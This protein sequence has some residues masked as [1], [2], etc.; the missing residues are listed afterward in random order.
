M[1]WA[2][3]AAAVA[4][5]LVQAVV[6][7][8]DRGEN[9]GIAGAGDPASLPFAL[10]TFRPETTIGEISAF[11]GETGAV[12]IAGPAAGGVFKIGIPADSEAEYDRIV[13]LIAAQPFAETVLAGR[14]PDD[15]G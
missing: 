7:P 6:E 4:L 15:G 11:L 1:A 2:A 8:W 5:L 10:V 12:V 3:A 9:F 14:K 13:G